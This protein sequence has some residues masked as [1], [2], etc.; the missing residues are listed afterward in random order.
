[1]IKLA[2]ATFIRQ[3]FFNYQPSSIVAQ[4][5]KYAARIRAEPA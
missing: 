5:F 3:S 4:T 2:T 1:M